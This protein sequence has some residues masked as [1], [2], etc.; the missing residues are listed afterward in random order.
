MALSSYQR[1]AN[2]DVDPES[3]ITTSLVTLLR[4]NPISALVQA[5]SAP[6]MMLRHD[7]TMINHAY[8]NTNPVWSSTNNIEAPVTECNT[9]SITGGAGTV[10]TFKR[11]FHII[12]AME[13]ITI[14]AALVHSN[15]DLLGEIAGNN[16]GSGSGGGGGGGVGGSFG[17]KISENGDPGNDSQY[18]SLPGGLAG[19]RS[20]FLNINALPGTPGFSLLSTSTKELAALLSYYVEGGSRGG[21]G[22]D[23]GWDAETGLSLPGGVGGIGGTG[24]GLLILVAPTIIFATLTTFDLRGGIGGVG[25]DPQSSIVGSGG[26]GGGG[27]GGSVIAISQGVNSFI[28]NGAA[29]LVS[30]GVGGAGGFSSTW[31]T[32]GGDGGDGGNGVLYNV[33]LDRADEI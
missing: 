25:Q 18:G 28:N 8:N 12:R 11:P 22:G 15:L 2:G 13:S 20:L 32:S 7:P 23:G 3:P 31:L 17:Y 19:G 10:I 27:G 33:E 4:D 29:P 16:V 30:G 5:A 24:G 26:G 1:I 21:A 14:N 9:L 6:D